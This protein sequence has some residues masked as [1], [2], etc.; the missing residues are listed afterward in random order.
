MISI[1]ILAAG[2]G[3]RMQSN[4]PK[5]LHTICGKSMIAY[6]I[7]EALAISSDI[8]IVLYHNKDSIMTYLQQHYQSHIIDKITLHTQLHDVYPGTGGALMQ[9][10]KQMLDIKGDRILILNGDTPLFFH[11]SMQHLLCG[12]G[13]INIA[14]FYTDKPDG[15]GRIIQK[16]EY[17]LQDST[18]GL[19]SFEIEE[20]IEDKDCNDEQRNNRYV[21]GGI[22]CFKKEILQKYIPQLQNNNAQK[23][24]YLTDIIKLACQD[25]KDKK[26]FAMTY[27]Y[28]EKVLMGI[29]TK[30]HLAK[31]QN[32]MLQILRQ[33]AMLQGVIMDMPESIYLDYEVQF[34][35][36]CKLEN[37]VRITGKSLI[38]DS[39]IKAH[40]VIETSQIVLSDVGPHAH[41]RPQ[42]TIIESHIGNFVECKNATLHG[43]KAGHLSYLGD[44]EI[45]DGTNVGAGVITCNYDGKSKHI[46]K[47]GKKVFIGSDCQLVAPVNIEDNVLIAAGSTITQNIKKGSLAI[48]RS[49]Q[50]NI[51]NGFNKFFDTK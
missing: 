36:E 44:C 14:G 32:I 20:I 25:N 31:A 43:V 21:N 48:A 45:Q 4:I 39:T 2:A 37:G 35:G 38:K 18:T 5:V 15:Y 40:S 11:D 19:H 22:Y 41:I 7:D 49:T 27:Q 13:D 10:E 3:T 42:S 34:E 24:Y 50:K 29:N 28:D 33:K 1:V 9:N 6:L 51:E 26:H 12:I 46:T 16:N 30:L 8:H 47:I 23:E 17:T